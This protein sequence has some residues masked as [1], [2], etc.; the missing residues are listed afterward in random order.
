MIRITVNDLVDPATGLR[1]V[2]MISALFK[3]NAAQR[4]WGATMALTDKG[5]AEAADKTVKLITDCARAAVQYAG[6]APL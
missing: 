4:E 5:G 3:R 2:R 1:N 6:S